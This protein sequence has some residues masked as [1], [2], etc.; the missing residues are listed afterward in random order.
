MYAVI[1][2]PI[3][4]GGRALENLSAVEALLQKR[5]ISYFVERST[6]DDGI[7]Q[8]TRR[9]A[10]RR[11]EGIIAIGGDGTLFEIV[12]GLPVCDIPLLFVSCGTGNDFIKALCLPGDPIAALEIQLD[13]PVRRI[14]L[15][16]MNDMR[17]INVA[18]TGFD[19]DVLR[20]LEKYKNRYTGLRAYMRALVDAIKHYRPTRAR[21]SIDDGPEQDMD[22]AILSIGNGR[23]IGG[24]MRAVPDAIVD[25]GLFD[26]VIVKPV[27]RFVILP[28]IAFFVSGKHVKLGLGR[29]VRCKKLKVHC[30]GMTLNMDGELRNTDDAEF[31][32]IPGGLCVRVPQ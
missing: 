5:G 3:S 13:A 6:Q 28:L 21:V 15:C 11:P 18:G 24:G 12:N 4:G 31:E 7:T 22:F 2:N 29:P 32:I 8:L 16:R 17:F 10:D 30:P 27:K 9:V 14:D 20:C 19:V 25:D 26:V 23:Y 1:L